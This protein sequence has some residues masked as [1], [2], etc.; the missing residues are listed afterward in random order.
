MDV[1][2]IGNLTFTKSAAAADMRLESCRIYQETATDSSA[3]AFDT[4][5]AELFT[6]TAGAQL[7]ALPTDAPIVITRDGRVYRSF[8]KSSVT[9]TGPATY[10][11]EANSPLSALAKREHRGGLY[12]GQSV[13]SV[14]EDICGGQPVI[15]ESVFAG[16]PLY[17]WLPY[18]R[19]P[20]ASARDN[21]VQVLFA[22]GAHL[23]T[24]LNGVLRVEKLWGG[25]SGEA[26]ETYSGGT[27][28]YDADISAVSLTEHQY[29]PGTEET[30]LF[31]GTASDGYL[32]TFSEPMHSL[33]A[34]GFRIQE[35]GANYARV[36]AGNGTLKGKKYRHSTRQITVEVTSEAAE[37][38]VDISNAT[39][40][41]V[42]NSQAVANRLAAF[43]KCRV[44]LEEG[45]VSSTEKPGHVIK[46]YD[47][48][49]KTVIECCVEKLDTTLSR[50]M[51][52]DMTARIGFRPPQP[53]AAEYYDTCV[54]LTGSGEWTV[55][56]GVGSARIV[57]IGGGTGGWSGLPGSAAD[58]GSQPTE[59]SFGT[60]Y[61][62]IWPG[63]G[64]AGGNAGEAGDGGK[65]YQTT[66]HL[67][68]GASIAYSCGT[69]G[70]GGVFSAAG[71]APGTVGGNT[72]FGDLSSMN[73]ANSENGFLEETGGRLYGAKGAAGTA[74]GSGTGLNED[75][76][77]I[78]QGESVKYNGTVYSP[79]ATDES[80]INITYPSGAQY[81]RAVAGNG[82]GGGAAAGANGNA[83]KT[84][85]RAS[86]NSAQAIIGTGDGGDGANAAAPAMPALYGTGGS[87]G[88]G[89]G[90]GG[91]CGAGVI[92]R[93]NNVSSVSG[94]SISRYPGTPGA[95]GDGSD[96][97]AGADG[98]IILYFRMPKALQPGP[99]VT[100]DGKSLLD[101]LGRRMIV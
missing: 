39:L 56:A 99:L 28:H 21:L 17:G 65:I 81:V 10:I 40:V 92:S 51:R 64:G 38:V 79:G 18:A 94:I 82:Y 97:G 26:T 36:S 60:T 95:G 98:C 5:T 76:T 100:S 35:S 86:I 48:Y 45:I 54:V 93:D 33:S 58:A 80:T 77:G 34:E 23:G 22:I 55:P 78:A 3:L 37:N 31:S 49:E 30:E 15:I 75:G 50:T 24:D 12:T 96:G 29:A 14:V 32:I 52:S 62:R 6:S 4:M 101:S 73:G 69:G 16:M 88:N 47:P 43:Y 9:R 44:L 2:K 84:N 13:K 53:E 72:T 1:L 90:G 25:V 91:G 63:R 57:L 83:G 41:S 67:S 46:A 66:L 8:L 68:P 89:G 61:Y 70:V 42:T 27:L 87:G 71:S 11:L 20:E 74:G 19:P 59:T 85:K 7:C